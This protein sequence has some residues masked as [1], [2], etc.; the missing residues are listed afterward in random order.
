MHALTDVAL[1]ALLS[2]G[3]A[4]R[5]RSA[6]T[7]EYLA[8]EQASLAL[9]KTGATHFWLQAVES[10]ASQ[11]IDWSGSGGHRRAKAEHGEPRAVACHLCPVGTGREYVSLQQA[12][13]TITSNTAASL[14]I[15]P[16]RDKP[17]LQLQGPRQDVARR[18]LS[19]GRAGQLEIKQAEEGGNV[20]QKVARILTGGAGRHAAFAVEV[21]ESSLSGEAKWAGANSG[22]KWLP[23][24]DACV[25]AMQRGLGVHLSIVPAKGL[26]SELEVLYLSPEGN[27]CKGRRDGAGSSL[28]AVAFA[29]VE[30]KKVLLET[31]LPSHS[32]GHLVA[33]LAVPP[34]GGASRG[35]D[36]LRRYIGTEDEGAADVGALVLVKHCPSRMLWRVMVEAEP[37]R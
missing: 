36:D 24:W 13:P 19:T 29:A 11:L 22:G 21:L 5:I 30:V 34:G 15:V 35:D 37:L 14:V 9:A 3:C 8:R 4:C 12:K 20:F 16:V 2:M 26:P 32:Q 31:F 25:L 1:P 10:E 18:M 33:L 27:L 28:S 17:W 23:L 6:V 7:G